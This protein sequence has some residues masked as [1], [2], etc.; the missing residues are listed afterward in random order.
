MRFCSHVFLVHSQGTIEE[1]NTIDVVAGKSVRV[2]VEFSKESAFNY[3]GS[4]KGGGTFQPELMK[5][6]VST[7]GF[8]FPTTYRSHLC[9]Q[10]LGGVPK[11]DEDAIFNEAVT[12]AS[13]ADTVVFIGGLTP[14]WESEGFDRDTLS[15]PG[16]QDELIAAIAAANHNTTVVLQVVSRCINTSFVAY[17]SDMNV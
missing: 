8:L 4:N 6:V 13:K 1:K 2:R 14:E 9:V 11:V 7:M 17:P 15:L 5:G 3:S 12:L 10:R 16:R